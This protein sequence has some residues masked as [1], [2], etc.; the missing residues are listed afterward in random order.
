MDGA[1]YYDEF[2]FY[3]KIVFSLE[4]F[5]SFWYQDDSQLFFQVSCG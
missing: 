5:N 4:L 2:L 3:M 1:V